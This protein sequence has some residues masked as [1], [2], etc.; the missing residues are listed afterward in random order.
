MAANKVKIR[1]FGDMRPGKNTSRGGARRI[2]RLR[3]TTEAQSEVRFPLSKR[4]GAFLTA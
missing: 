4:P 2:G 3:R 1:F